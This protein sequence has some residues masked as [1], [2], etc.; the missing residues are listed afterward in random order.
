MGKNKGISVLTCYCIDADISIYVYAC[1]ML[2]QLR[3]LINK[4]VHSM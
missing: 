3:E 1:I 2:L 4:Y